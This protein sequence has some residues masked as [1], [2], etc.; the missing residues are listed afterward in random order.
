MNDVQHVDRVF[1]ATVF[2]ACLNHHHFGKIKKQF[3]AEIIRKQLTPYTLTTS[4]ALYACI[5]SI[6]IEGS[7][8]SARSSI[9]RRYHV[10]LWNPKICSATK[11][12]LHWKTTGEDDKPYSLGVS[13]K[14][15][16][17]NLKI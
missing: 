12:Q 4:R 10:K 6:M 9:D 7:E 11:T 16:I 8:T 14:R 15:N 13:F 17:N 2:G 1:T 5:H 3:T